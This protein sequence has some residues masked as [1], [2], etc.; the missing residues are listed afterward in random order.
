M[1]LG[2]V[3]ATFAA[4][5]AGAT[6]VRVGTRFV[7]TPEANSHPDYV[8]ALVRAQA[9][10]TVLTTALSVMWPDAHSGVGRGSSA[11]EATGRARFSQ[12]A[13]IDADAEDLFARFLD[14]FLPVVMEDAQTRDDQKTD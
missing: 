7:A 14:L 11:A 5:A 6:G 12:A 4:G 9:A 1:H 2:V 13:R 8:D 3:A 10:D